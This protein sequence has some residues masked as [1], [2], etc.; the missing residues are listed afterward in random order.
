MEQEEDLRIG[1]EVA[2]R[3]AVATTGSRRRQGR[4]RKISSGDVSSHDFYAVYGE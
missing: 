2:G 1:K 4:K 3:I